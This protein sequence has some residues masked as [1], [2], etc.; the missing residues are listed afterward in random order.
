MLILEKVV[1]FLILMQILATL[2]FDNFLKPA[3]TEPE[4]EKFGVKIKFTRVFGLFWAAV[5]E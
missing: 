2:E 4:Q 3:Y 5:V 1:K